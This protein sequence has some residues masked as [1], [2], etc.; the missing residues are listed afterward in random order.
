MPLKKPPKLNAAHQT[1]RAHPI[2]PLQ[3][4]LNAPKIREV[5]VASITRQN[6]TATYTYDI[7]LYF[8]LPSL[9]GMH[10]FCA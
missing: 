6:K 8:Q 3:N 10:A 4:R 2:E 1:T 5:D 7:S 9:C